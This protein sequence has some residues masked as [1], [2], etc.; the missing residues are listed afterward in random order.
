MLSLL[1]GAASPPRIESDIALVLVSDVSRSIDD[2]EFALEKSGYASALTDPKV[3]AALQGGPTGRI[4][5]AYVEFAG[6]E[7]VETVLGW[8]MISDG[9]SAHRVATELIDAPRSFRGRT[10]IGAGLLRANALLADPSLDAA[11]RVIDVAGDGTNNDGPDSA[12][13]RD[14]LVE[15]GVTVNG[16]AIINDHPANYSY[17]HT[18]PPGGLAEYYRQHVM[19]GPGSFV[20]EVHDF[21]AFGDAIVRKLL[22]EIACAC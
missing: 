19:G 18:Q 20:V 8:T 5:L 10:A 14:A 3:I 21:H 22:S 17:A 15:A 11:R 1:L 4:A 6:A 16:L 7:E 9:E 2:T 12:M 13:V